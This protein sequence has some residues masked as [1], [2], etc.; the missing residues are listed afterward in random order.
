MSWTEIRAL[1]SLIIATWA[2]WFLQ[3]RFLDGG[4]VVDLPPE[5]MF[6]T[7]LSVIVVTII[8]EILVTIGISI[9]GVVL[10]SGTVESADFEDERD[11]Q[12]ERRA[13]IISYWFLIVVVNILALRLIQQEIY[14]SSVFA[15]LAIASTS[16]IVFTLLAVLFAAHIVKMAAKLIL[17]R[18]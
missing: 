17:Y 14:T 4:Q 13:G 15:P 5:R 12:I 8:G 7:Y 16:G 2:L 11:K 9:V 1:G 10:N 6:S 3:M 18:V